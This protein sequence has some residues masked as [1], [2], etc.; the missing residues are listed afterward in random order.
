MARWAGVNKGPLS[1]KRPMYNEEERQI[2]HYARLNPTHTPRPDTLLRMYVRFKMGDMRGL[3]PIFEGIDK[4]PIRYM[5]ELTH[6]GGIPD[7]K[8]VISAAAIMSILGTDQVEHTDVNPQLARL[9]SLFVLFY[10]GGDEPFILNVEGSP[11]TIEAG[12]SY[13]LPAY[14]P[15]S[16]TGGAHGY[17]LAVLFST[18]ELTPEIVR[19][20]R[21]DAKYLDLSK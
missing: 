16:G 18:Q 21:E 10:N 11:L 19:L 20:I 2:T 3:N 5:V 4:Q 15:H 9:H 1:I 6:V 17:R 7:C 13:V 8:C 12:E 14:M